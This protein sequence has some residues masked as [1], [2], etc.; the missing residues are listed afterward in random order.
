VKEFDVS[1]A[2]RNIQARP[3]QISSPAST[4]YFIIKAGPP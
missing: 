4:L 1:E 2:E 3:T